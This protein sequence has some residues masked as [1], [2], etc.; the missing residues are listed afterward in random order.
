[1]ML[2]GAI[3]P[4]A[5]HRPGALVYAAGLFCTGL[6][7]FPSFTSMLRQRLRWMRTVY[8]PPLAAVVL[9]LGFSAVGGSLLPHNTPATAQG[10]TPHPTDGPKPQARSGRET[11]LA[12]ADE[13]SKQGRGAESIML[14]SR[15][16]E[17]LALNT[18]PELKAAMARA[19]AAKNREDAPDLADRLLQDARSDQLLKISTQPPATAQDLWAR[20]DTFEQYARELSETSDSTAEL[21]PARKRLKAA[22]LAVQRR[23]FPLLREGYRRHVIGPGSA[24]WEANVEVSGSGRTI[25]FTSGTFSSNHNIALAEQGMSSNLNKLRFSRVEYRWYSCQSGGVVYS[26]QVPGDAVIGYWEADTFHKVP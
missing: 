12:E 2:F 18:D 4:F 11:D 26:P 6:V 8:A 16:F 22:L 3:T 14:L 9:L 19:K 5:D 7:I 24:L 10:P 25:T 17:P 1:M 23:Q 13:L 20:L 21:S 15:R